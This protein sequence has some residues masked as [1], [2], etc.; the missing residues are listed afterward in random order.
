MTTIT[1]LTSDITTVTGT[2]LIVEGGLDVAGEDGRI[3]GIKFYGSKIGAYEVYTPGTS[4]YALYQ[5]TNSTYLNG[6][7]SLFF[8][9]MEDTKMCVISSGNVGIATTSPVCPLEVNKTTTNTTESGLFWRKDSTSGQAWAG[10]VNTLGTSIKALG[11]V[12]T[13]DAFV[14]ASDRRIKTTIIDIQDDTAL[15]LFRR[16]QPKTYEYVDKVRKGMDTVYGFIAQEV[17]EVLPLA[18]KTITDTIPNIYTIASAAGD[19]LTFDTS[20]LE[21]DASGQLFPKLKLIK[22][23]DTEFYVQILSVS[24]N[25]V[26]I[27]QTLTEDKVFVYGQEVDNFHTLNKDAIWTV[28][29]AALQEVDRQLQAEKSKTAV[30]EQKC[31]TLE[32]KYDSLQSNYEALLVRIVALESKG[33]AT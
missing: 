18:A 1:T 22:E 11:S 15:Q 16:I 30:L 9:I 32:A 20:K 17:R 27:D 3:G 29:A 13:S 24:G 6:V 10:G 4:K 14:A 12:L 2:F 28:A 25:T 23:D 5:D 21:Y 26:Q 33:L 31:L 7:Y 19:R 8:N